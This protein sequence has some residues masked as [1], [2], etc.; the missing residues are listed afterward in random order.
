MI[1]HMK[2]LLRLTRGDN[3]FLELLGM[4]TEKILV[5]IVNNLR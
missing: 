4:R 1:I 5:K 3:I 2:Q